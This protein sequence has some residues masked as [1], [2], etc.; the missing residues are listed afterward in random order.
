MLS[1]DPALKP[2]DASL[3]RVKV[4]FDRPTPVLEQSEC[5][6]RAASV[7]PSSCMA[8]ATLSEALDRQVSHSWCSRLSLSA[9]A[10]LSYALACLLAG[11]Q[12]DH[13]LR[14]L[15]H[16]PQPGGQPSRL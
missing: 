12:P 8:D 14:L 15:P 16:R 4:I 5:V 2:T 6:A 9:A 13:A 3:E 1:V 7:E 10:C 11:Q